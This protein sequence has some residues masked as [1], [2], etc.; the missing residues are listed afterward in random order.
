M[1]N[2]VEYLTGIALG[3]ER[4]PGALCLGPLLWCLSLVYGVVVWVYR[5]LYQTGVL[6]SF[7]AGVPVISVGNITAGGTGKT[8]FVVMLYKVLRQEGY[9]PMVLTRGYMGGQS[10]FSDEARM[11]QELIGPKV[12]VGADRV[13]SFQ[14][15]LKAGPFDCVILDDGFQQWGFKRDLDI[16]LLDSQKPFGNGN[17][18]PGGILRETGS[19]LR[20]A[21]IIV[22]TRADRVS[23][24]DLALLKARLKKV[25]PRS[26][27]A[28]GVHA[29]SAARDVSGELNNALKD[30]SGPAGAFCAIGDPASFQSTL[31]VLGI[32]LKFFSSFPDHYSFN[33]ADVQRIIAQCREK[34]VTRVFITHKD[35][36]KLHDHRG[37]FNGIRLIVIDMELVLTYG[38]TELISSVRRLRNS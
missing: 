23:E 2:V 17:L 38:K 5:G 22:L 3:R 21:D 33:E 13:K 6:R 11:V 27:Q 10:G 28:V 16:V 30:L 19:E 18:I 14:A 31:A 15:A 29:F 20:R 36:V 12:F 32:E 4:G 26:A 37:L 8:P 1:K 9:H 24:T 25:F 7:R 34:D 35:L